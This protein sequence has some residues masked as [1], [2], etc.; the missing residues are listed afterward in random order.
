MQRNALTQLLSRPAMK[1]AAGA[2]PLA[3][4]PSWHGAVCA[5]FRV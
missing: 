5:W 3:L 2:R 4:L 1:E